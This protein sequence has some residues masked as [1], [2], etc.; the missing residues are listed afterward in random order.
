M[1]TIGKYDS[2]SIS[3]LFG[4]L[5]SQKSGANTNFGINLSDYSMIKGGSYYKM[6]R[7]YYSIDGTETESASWAQSKATTSTSRDSAKTL[8]RIESA[9]TDLE[10]SAKALYK[11]DTKSPF[12]KGEDGSYDTEAIY[13]AVDA[14]VSD[15]NSMISATDKSETSRIVN[16][17][18]SMERGTDVNAKALSEIGITKNS[19]GTLKIDEEVFKKSDMGKVKTLFSGNGSYAYSTAVSASMINGYAKQESAKANTYN[20]SGNYTYN[21]STGQLYNDSF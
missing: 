13:K 2:N 1:M 17:A 19:D 11:N 6:M 15:Y 21:Y 9:A 4:G 10:E 7:A 16:A 12:R 14:F 20:G 8:A 5:N 18:S 3:T